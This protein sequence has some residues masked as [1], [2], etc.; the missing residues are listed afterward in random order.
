MTYNSQDVKPSSKYKVL[1]VDDE[2]DIL[3]FLSY[4]LEQEGFT[5]FVADSGKKALKIA[6]QELPELILLDVMMP[7]MDGIKTCEKIRKISSLKNT[8]IAF[9]TARNEDYSQ[10]AGFEAGADDYIAKPIRP[11]VLLSRIKALL[12]RHV[13]NELASKPKAR[14]EIGNLIVEVNKHRV[15]LNKKKIVLPRKEFNLLLLLISE[16]EKVF[17]RESI[18]SLIWGNQVIVGD[19]TIDVHIRKL[20]EKIGSQYIK[21]V[22]G[23]GYAFVSVPKK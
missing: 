21:T 5:V 2:P 23:V 19:R 12:K 16:P 10:I 22:K 14:I 20:R 9:L 8:L 18:Y 3:E 13:K 1:I 4:N 6:K 15:I 17:T 11:R 7:E